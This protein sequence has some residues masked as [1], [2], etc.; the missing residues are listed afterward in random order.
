MISLNSKRFPNS[1]Y[2][3]YGEGFPLVL[4]HGFGET[5]DI[6]QFQIENLQKYYRLI[7]PEIPG[8]PHSQLPQEDM[9]MELI[10]DFVHEISIQ[11]KLEKVILCGH[12]MGGYATLA[13]AEK[14]AESLAAFGL[15]HS[16]ALADS[17]EKIQNREKAIQLILNGGKEA[18]LKAMTPNLYS[19]DSNQRIPELVQRHLSAALTI[20]TEALIAYYKGMIARRD[21]KDILKESKVPVLFVF[22]KH[23]NLIPYKEALELLS[24]PEVSKLELFENVGHTSMYECPQNLNICINNFCKEV[25]NDKKN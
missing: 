9:T 13:Y 22:G 3:V 21:R 16:T 11:E 15:I 1:Y 25:L 7:V 10:A 14:Y 17:S 18:F 4:L 2:S 12:S 23:D 19:E 5:A 24:L 6:F 8:T 20:E